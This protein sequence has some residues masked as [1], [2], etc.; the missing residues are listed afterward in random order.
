MTIDEWI[1][2]TPLAAFME[3]RGTPYMP[4][5]MTTEIP[6]WARWKAQD[7]NGCWHVFESRP[8]KDMPLHRWITRGLWA[9]AGHSGEPN[10][11]WEGS[12]TRVCG[13]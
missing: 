9:P 5:P 13:R 10:P 7:M 1:A 6:H 12:L 4:K 11:R 3:A 8:R 2:G